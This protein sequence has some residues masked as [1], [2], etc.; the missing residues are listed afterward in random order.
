[1]QTL[2][3][4]ARIDP[5]YATALIGEPPVDPSNRQPAQPKQKAEDRARYIGNGVRYG[6]AE[7]GGERVLYKREIVLFGSVIGHEYKTV[8]QRLGE[9][10][11]NQ[12]DRG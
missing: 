3:K 11:R 10:G 2:R 12:R 7:C 1:M 6:T 5:K 8:W 9:R 4:G